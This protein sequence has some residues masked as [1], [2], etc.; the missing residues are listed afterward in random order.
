MAVALIYKNDDK[1]PLAKSIVAVVLP[2]KKVL[3]QEPESE[4]SDYIG[5]FPDRWKNDE[6]NY[7][8]R[9]VDSSGDFF[10]KEFP[11]GELTAPKAD[12]EE[13]PLSALYW[14]ILR[15]F[16]SQAMGSGLF[17]DDEA[18]QL[19]EEGGWFSDN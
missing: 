8:T 7:R 19:L 3:T 14:E 6:G 18:R 10:E 2:S 17:S 11:D 5:E 9:I 4:I 12:E 16:D 13:M 1:L 15:I